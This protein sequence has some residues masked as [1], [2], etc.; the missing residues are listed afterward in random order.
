M[1]DLPGPP[2]LPSSEAVTVML[3]WHACVGQS[4]V[5]LLHLTHAERD[6]LLALTASSLVPAC[7]Q[8]RPVSCAGAL[9]SALQL[10]RAQKLCCGAAPTPAHPNGVARSGGGH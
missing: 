6:P 3:W 2:H 8:L 1:P 4:L 7:C 9:L 5:A 10:Q